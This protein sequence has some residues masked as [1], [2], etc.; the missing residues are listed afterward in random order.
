[1]S[2]V[3]P[4]WAVV[5]RQSDGLTIYCCKSSTHSRIL[6]KTLDWRS[7]RLETKYWF[8]VAALPTKLFDSHNVSIERKGECDL[9][10][11]VLTSTFSSPFPTDQAS[12]APTSLPLNSLDSS[13]TSPPPL[14]PD[15]PWAYGGTVLWGPRLDFCESSSFFPSYQNLS[16]NIILPSFSLSL[17]DNRRLWSESC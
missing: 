6:Q 15:S 10:T 3:L 14:L 13:T 17:I 4:L 8:L 9:W 5:W 2:S 12:A 7:S 16:P 11:A 1:M